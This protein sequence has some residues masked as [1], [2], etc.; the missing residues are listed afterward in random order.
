MQTSSVQ[1]PLVLSF[2]KEGS[3]KKVTFQNAILNVEKGFSVKPSKDRSQ[4]QVQRKEEAIIP[5]PT[6]QISLP[7]PETIS[8]LLYLWILLS[9]S[10]F[11]TTFINRRTYIF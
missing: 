9:D 4:R 5:N 7:F 6:D 3:V 11:Y 8:P 1:F 2:I 10:I